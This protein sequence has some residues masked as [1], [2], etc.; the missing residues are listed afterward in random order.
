MLA[1]RWCSI[2]NFRAPEHYKSGAQIGKA[3]KGQAPRIVGE[4]VALA[5]L[6]LAA[7]ASLR[8]GDA[9]A[10]EGSGPKWHV[11]SVSSLLPSTACTAAKGSTYD[12]LA[13]FVRFTVEKF[14]YFTPLNWTRATV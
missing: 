1:L 5:V 2:T 3:L 10:A 12:A 6:V 4:M 9:A 7:L 8:H 13:L 14:F 11:V